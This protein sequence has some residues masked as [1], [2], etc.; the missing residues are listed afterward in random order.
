M[1]R[2]FNTPEGTPVDYE[3]MVATRIHPDDREKVKAA[4][5]QGAATGRYDCKYR[6]VNNDGSVT[7]VKACS[8][9]YVNSNGTTSMVG[10]VTDITELVM[11]QE[12]V[13]C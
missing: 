8:D 1:H 13:R 2:L 7:H 9:N 12:Q 3:E 6:I 11:L 5:A 4:V 10:T